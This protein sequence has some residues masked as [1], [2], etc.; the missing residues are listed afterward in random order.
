MSGSEEIQQHDKC[1]HDRCHCV[2]D[3]A[4]AVVREKSVFCSEGC[5]EGRGCDH[6][7]CGCRAA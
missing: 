4:N 6:P 5:A 2:P 3:A 7:K 1:D